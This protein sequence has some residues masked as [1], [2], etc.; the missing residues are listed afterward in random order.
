VVQE[1]KGNFDVLVTD[2]RMPGMDGVTLAEHVRAN[3]PRIPVLLVSAYS[4]DNRALRASSF[5]AK[6]FLPRD[7]VARVQKLLHRR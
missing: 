7:L 2:V 1:Q 3:F 6:P 4:T 5:L